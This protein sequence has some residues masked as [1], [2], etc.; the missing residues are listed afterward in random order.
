MSELIGNLSI[1]KDLRGW[2]VNW[3]KV[4]IKGKSKPVWNKKNPGARA[5]LLSGPPGIGKRACGFL[6]AGLRACLPCPP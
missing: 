5:V 4:H 1:A 2:L 3:T 6:R